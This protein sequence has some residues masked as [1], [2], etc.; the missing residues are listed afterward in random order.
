MDSMYA[1]QVWDLVELSKW[2]K[3]FGCEWVYKRNR[4]PDGNVEIFKARL[5][6]KGHTQR[7]GIDYEEIFSPVAMLKSIWILLTIAA[8]HD[9]DIWQMDVKTAFLNGFLEEDIYMEQ[10][11]GFIS[12]ETSNL[13]CKLQK[14]IYG[15]KQTSRSWNHHF[16]EIIRLYGFI[17][18]RKNYVFI[19]KSVRAW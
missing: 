6:V 15:L 10:P 2:V 4:G 3:P 5:V 14:S 1:N 19:T 9:Y 13:V 16:D 11:E 18:M 12:S 8:Y 17:K 7:P